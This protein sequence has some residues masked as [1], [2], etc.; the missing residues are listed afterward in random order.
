MALLF[1]DGFDKYGPA[2]SFTTTIATLL[3]AGEWTSSV[4]TN[5]GI[6]NGLS[7]TGFA[8]ALSAGSSILKTFSS[9]Y[10]RL[11]GGVRIS[12]TLTQVGGVQFTDGT[13]A[14]ASINVNTTGTISVRNGAITGTALATSTATISANTTHYLEWDFTFANAPTG[15]YQVWL[16][17]VSILSGTGDTTA[18]ANA[19]ANGIQLAHGA[20]TGITT[21]DD[22]YLFDTTGS[23]NNAALLNTPRIETTFP[24]A[25]NAVQF[26]FGAAVLGTPIVRNS[27]T[28]A[29]AA[30]SLVLRRFVPNQAGTLN[31]ISIIIGGISN[32]SVNYRPV[33]YADS[34]GVAGTLMSTG[35]TITGA[36][37]NATITMP[38]TTPQSL[39]A[40][41]PYWLGFMVD[42]SLALALTDANNTGYRAAATFISG[43]P[44]TAPTMTT[45][46][47]SYHLWGNISGVAV[48]Y[49]E[50]N[51]Q[52]PPGPYSFVFDATAGHADLY[53]FPAL[54]TM[55][56]NVHAVALKGYLQKSDSGARTVS[57]RVV[58]A[59]TDD[60]G[61]TTGQALGTTYGWLRSFWETDPATGAAWTGAAI[62]AATSGV[63]IDS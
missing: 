26:G 63:R 32:G 7:A 49:P 1:L 18:T 57:L 47:S 35:S 12:S 53:D 34:G 6:A 10:S 3:T 9:N 60:G 28:A 52:P 17:G 2:T 42:L 54:N 62:N 44:G 36:T 31:S 11:I 37:A 15:S 45:G 14:Q 58:S 56:A 40:G 5:I 55:P 38:L 33:V 59:G 41:T 48:N 25:D 4:A 23:R 13:T 16:D 39:V 30:N 8:L 27:T 50:V 43:A 46:Q 20:T 24:S 21:F 19:Y 51:Q 22:L 29:P 61:S